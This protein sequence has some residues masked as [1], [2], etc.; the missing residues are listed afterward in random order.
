M[1]I[2]KGWNFI[3]LGLGLLS[4]CLLLASCNTTQKNASADPGAA[5]PGMIDTSGFLVTDFD[6]LNKWLD[7]RFKVD[8]KH[9][10]PELVFDQVPLNDIFYQTENLPKNPKPFNF[11]S[12][13]VSR[14]ELLKEISNHWKL[15]MSLSADESG[16]PTAV[17]VTG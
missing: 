3:A 9:M 16:N 6:P 7:E 2:C 15:K 10:T 17:I 4:A 13:D 1:K 5:G 12:Q 11:S 8:Y 14:R